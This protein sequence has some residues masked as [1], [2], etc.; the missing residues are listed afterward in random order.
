MTT[1]STVGATPATGE[2]SASTA[3]ATT[4][5]ASGRTTTCKCGVCVSI[6]RLP[7]STDGMPNR[8][9]IDGMAPAAGVAVDESSAVDVAGR[10]ETEAKGIPEESCAGEPGVAVGTAGPRPSRTIAIATVASVGLGEVEVGV[11]EVLRAQTAPGVEIVVGLYL[12][13]IKFLAGS[14]RLR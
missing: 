7:A 4:T 9:A 10:V 6:Y 3:E 11:A 8:M 2:A 12:F 13:R 1:A 14:R 5:I